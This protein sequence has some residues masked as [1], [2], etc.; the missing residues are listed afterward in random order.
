MPNYHLCFTSHKEVLFR[1]EADMHV[2]FNSLCSAIYK[3]DSTCFAYADMSDH[4][5]GCYRTKVPG[6]LMRTYRESYT[7]LFNR[8][9]F[10]KG[11]L[12]ER[13]F[14]LQEITGLKHFITAV[15]YVLK[16]PP[17]HGVTSTPFEY[18]F[19]S[20]NAY[21]RKELGK[22]TVPDRLLSYPQIKKVLPRRAEFNPEWKMGID[23][24]FLPES[25][26]DVSTVE[27]S[28]G[29][30]QAFNYYLGRKSGNDW[31][32]EQEEEG[33]EPFTLENIEAP[34]MTGPF[35]VSIEEMLRNERSRFRTVAMTDLELCKIID[36]RSLLPYRKQSV[37]LL[38]EKEKNEIAN[39]IYRQFHIG[40]LQIKRCIAM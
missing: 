18:P 37:Y 25:V 35:P 10:R 14:Y 32:K 20:A 8:K 22:D 5:H 15:A 3:T 17:H 27:T 11:E 21:F 24:V 28:F 39:S 4:H 29:T 34:L 12:G 13:G 9:Y 2:G 19:S 23:G 31:V 38:T 7:K 36:T 40:T 16:N 30:A 33:T 26:L 6:E 1:N